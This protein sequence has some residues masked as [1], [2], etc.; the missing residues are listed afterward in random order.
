MASQSGSGASVDKMNLQALAAVL[1]EFPKPLEVR[2]GRLAAQD[3]RALAVFTAC[4]LAAC[5]S[6]IYVFVSSRFGLSLEKHWLAFAVGT[7]VGGATM[8]STYAATCARNEAAVAEARAAVLQSA[9]SRTGAAGKRRRVAGDKQQQQQ[10]LL[11]QEHLELER[12]MTGTVALEAVAFS[13]WTNNLAFVALFF[14]SCF[15]AVPLLQGGEGPSEDAW[16]W[17]SQLNYCASVCLPALLLRVLAKA[18]ESGRP[19]SKSKA[20]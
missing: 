7:V 19:E 11:Q 12:S 4:G 2:G 3:W 5:A 14:A 17:N 13:L 16:L 18:L 1:D 6:P 9:S 15:W 10:Q 8:A 20:S